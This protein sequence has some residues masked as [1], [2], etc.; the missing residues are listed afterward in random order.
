MQ[1]AQPSVLVGLFASRL[2]PVVAAGQSIRKR[3][4]FCFDVLIFF[5]ITHQDSDVERLLRS[6]GALRP[7]GCVLLPFVLVYNSI[8]IYLLPCFGVYLGRALGGFLGAFCCCICKKM[9]WYYYRDYAWFGLTALGDTEDCTAVEMGKKVDWVRANA[10]DVA[11]EEK[12]MCLFHG[13]IEPADL[14]QGAVGDCWLVAAMA[15]MAEHPG[16]IRNCFVNTEYNDRGKYKVRLWDGRAGKW[17][18]IVVDDYFPVEKGTK[19]CIYM[20][21][22]GGELWAILMEKAFAKFCGSYGALDG[23]WAVW[24]WHAMTGDNVLQFRSKGERWNRRNMVFIGN[25]TSVENRRRIGFSSTDD[26]IDEE[27]FFNVLL[28][29]SHKHSVMGASMILKEAEREERMDDGLVAGHMYSIL[30]VR[31]AGATMRF[32][33]GTKLLKLRN[34][35]GTFEWKGAWSDGS[36][37]WYGGGLHTHGSDAR[38]ARFPSSRFVISYRSL[39]LH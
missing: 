23:G 8:A 6:F 30:Q 27:T 35:W 1:R 39:H 25:D 24:A 16:A 11:G 28:K 9:G 13:E 18:T 31:R 21:P 14:C 33:G 4:R 38:R 19:K 37:E 2:G 20:K 34:P 36:D 3:T 7:R 15:G 22:N 12:R 10:L 5:K 32:H 29:Y 17:H 26:D